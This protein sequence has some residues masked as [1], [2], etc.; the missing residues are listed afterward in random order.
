[1]SRKYLTEEKFDEW[2]NNHFAH[3]VQDVAKNKRMV[4]LS[5]LLLSAI[6]YQTEGVEKLVSLIL[7]AIV[8]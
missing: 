5:L 4:Y 8:G 6:L 2:K 1:V 7:K 3:L